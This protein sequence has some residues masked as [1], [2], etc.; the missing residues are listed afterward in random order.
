[1]TTHPARLAITT[2]LPSSSPDL[3]PQTMTPLSLIPTA[4]LKMP[5]VPLSLPALLLLL[6]TRKHRAFDSQHVTESCLLP[7]LRVSGA[8]TTMGW[9]LCIFLPPLLPKLSR[10]SAT[11]SWCCALQRV[12]C[13]ISCQDANLHSYWWPCSKL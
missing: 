4:P 8:W 10:K 13:H 5:T 2:S 11:G 6:C 3:Y 1:V 12:Y 7:S 9:I